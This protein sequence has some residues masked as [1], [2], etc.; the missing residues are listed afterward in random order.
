MLAPRGLPPA[1]LTKIQGDVQAALSSAAVREKLLGIGF[2]SSW[3][4]GADYLK[5]I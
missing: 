3:M 4:E 2:Q 5:F 1:V